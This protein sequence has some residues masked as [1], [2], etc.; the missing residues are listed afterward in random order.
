MGGHEA[1]N[2]MRFTSMFDLQWPG[3]LRDPLAMTVGRA[4][5]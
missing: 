4:R 3:D 1:I 5:A 2:G